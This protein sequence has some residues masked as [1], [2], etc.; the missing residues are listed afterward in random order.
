[1]EWWA[2]ESAGDGGRGRTSEEADTDKYKTGQLI[3][4]IE[5]IREPLKS[6][7]ASVIVNHGKQLVVF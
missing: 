3:T 1:M 2:P 7:T 5:E 4:V 6:F